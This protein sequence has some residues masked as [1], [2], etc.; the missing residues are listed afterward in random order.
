MFAQR[1]CLSVVVLVCSVRANIVLLTL[2]SMVLLFRSCSLAV[3]LDWL[4]LLRVCE[5]SVFIDD[6]DWPICVRPFD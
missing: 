5:V 3:R 2:R 1:P 4:L 6:N